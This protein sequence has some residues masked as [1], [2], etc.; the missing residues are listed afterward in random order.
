ME[1]QPVS[2]IGS[3]APPRECAAHRIPPRLD[4]ARRA[5][6]VSWASEHVVGG[7]GQAAEDPLGLRSGGGAHSGF[8]AFLLV[9]PD[10]TRLS[11]DGAPFEPRQ[12]TNAQAR[13]ESKPKEGKQ[14]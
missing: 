3:F 11:V 6:I 9:E 14:P 4:G 5:G 2:Q 13:V 8:A 7:V 1:S 10:H 12:F